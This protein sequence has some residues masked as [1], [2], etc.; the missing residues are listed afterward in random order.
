MFLLSLEQAT[1]GSWH[2]SDPRVDPRGVR[3]HPSGFRT[4]TEPSWR[5]SSDP[6]RYGRPSQRYPPSRVPG[7]LHGSTQDIDF[8]VGAKGIQT[9][10]TWVTFFDE[11]R[12]IPSFLKNI[13]VTDDWG[14][15]RGLP[16]NIFLRFVKVFICDSLVPHKFQIYY[17]VIFSFFIFT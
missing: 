9:K 8:Q 5:E 1:C 4:R 7:L 11:N 6:S 12:L 13:D 2:S 17:K 15:R 16:C 10:R 14:C 3:A